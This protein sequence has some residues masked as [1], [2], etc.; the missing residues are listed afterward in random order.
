[1]NPYLGHPSQLYGIEEHRLIGG[2][3]DGMRL[4]EINNG[5]GIE[6]TC[7]PDRNGDISRLR[8]KGINMSYFSPCGYVAPAFYSRQGNHWLDSFT[9]G[10]LT[11]C[12]LQSVGSPCIDQGEELPFHGTIANQP[13]DYF[14]WE[15]N[16]DKLVVYL[17][18][19]E[20]TIF[21]RKFVLKRELHIS[22]TENCF[23]I[24]DTITNNGYKKEPFEILY[25]MNMGYPLLDED[26]ILTISSDKVIPRDA[27][28]AKY[29]DQWMK[30]EKPTPGY[31]E[32][33]YYHNFIQKEGKAS[34]YQPKLNC[35]LEITFDPRKLDGFVEWKMMGL[36][37]Y[38][39]GLECGNC[40]PD[41]RDIM[42]QKGMLKF[43]NAG[44]SVQYQVNVRLYD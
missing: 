13:C 9:A 37:D 7:V 40:Y 26:S 30:V 11:T 15:E 38:V 16:E 42:R 17:H 31:E 21:G 6:L 18:T 33:C 3:G 28:A 34:I 41:G 35:G 10:Y 29:M 4:L 8:Y 32:C 23:S 25:H 5:I 1:M 27:H 19:S 2:K 39:L 36:R 14:Y 20:E 12:G 43:L 22:L 24:I 44:E